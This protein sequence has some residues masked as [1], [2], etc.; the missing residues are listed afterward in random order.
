M[1]HARLAIRVHHARHR[2]RDAAHVH[3]ADDRHDV[4]RVVADHRHD[5]VHDLGEIAGA[6]LGGLRVDVRQRIPGVAR[7][8]PAQEHAHALHAIRVNA[9]AAGHHRVALDAH[10]H[11]H[12]GPALRVDQLAHLLLRG[13]VREGDVARVL[14]SEVVRVRR[15]D[16]ARERAGPAAV[17]HVPHHPHADARVVGDAAEHLALI[18][19]ELVVVRALRA[20]GEEVPVVRAADRGRVFAEGFAVGTVVVPAGRVRHAA[21]AV[22]DAEELHHRRGR[23]RDAAAHRVVRRVVVVAVAAAARALAPVRETAVLLETVH[24]VDLDSDLLDGVLHAHERRAAAHAEPTPLPAL[25]LGPR[26][27]FGRDRRRGEQRRAGRVFAVET[28]EAETPT[29]VAREDAAQRMRGGQLAGILFK[30]RDHGLDLRDRRDD[31][32]AAALHRH[33]VPQHRV[34]GVRVADREHGLR[35]RTDTERG[36]ARR[37]RVGGHHRHVGRN[38]VRACGTREQHGDKR[39]NKALL[40]RFLRPFQTSSSEG[41]VH[42]PENLHEIIHGIRAKAN[43][44]IQFLA[45]KFPDRFSMKAPS[46][47]ATTPFTSTVSMPAANACGDI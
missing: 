30:R 8:A 36:V 1:D 12:A 9:V 7:A 23:R 24:D 33:L 3:L 26:L 27:R 31:Q 22:R 40:H 21:R 2:D 19:G 17:Q 15:G 38:V 47:Y 34:R 6:A 37:P 20:V 42:F 11:R 43:E 18:E 46:R 29:H 5:A 44:K 10:A 16:F 39:Q 45:R 41:S 4:V 25:R 14:E 35:G 32:A 13:V 28:E